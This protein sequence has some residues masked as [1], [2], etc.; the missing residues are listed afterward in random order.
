MFV[1]AFICYEDGSSKKTVDEYLAEFDSLAA[2]EIPIILFLDK[3]LE[4]RVN[5]PNVRVVYLTIQDLWT[6]QFVR[7][8]VKRPER[9]ISD[10]PED[11]YLITNAKTEFMV[12]AMK[13]VPDER[14]SWIDFGIM[15]ILKHHP[16]T[17]AQL[18][19]LHHLGCG[20]VIPG[21]EESPTSDIETLYWRFLGGFFTGHLHDLI[22]FYN[23]HR[24]A[25]QSLYPRLHL[26]VMLWAWAETHL[27]FS[28][29]WY[30]ADFRD[31][32]FDF[33]HLLIPP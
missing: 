7:S 3:S 30:K 16:Q 28:P 12:R 31:K 5:Y 20:L 18:N 25:F 9:R 22:S 19:K 8:Q 24:Q 11:Y 17:L 6:Y 26:E 27:G 33:D 4:G 1:S 13:L 14:L 10:P 2:T 23:F 32:F 15:H 29:R 21:W